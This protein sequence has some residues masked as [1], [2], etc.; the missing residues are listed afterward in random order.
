MDLSIYLSSLLNNH[1]EVGVNGLGTF[2][3]KKV[4]GRYDAARHMFLP[5][6]SALVFAAE[7]REDTLLTDLVARERQLTHD[8]ASAAVQDFASQ[9]REGIR[10][11]GSYQLNGLGTLRQA[12]EELVFEADANATGTEFYGLPPM[13]EKT[14]SDPID[15]PVSGQAAAPDET[16]PANDEPADIPSI[17]VLP[18]EQVDGQVDG[19]NSTETGTNV[20]EAQP[21]AVETDHSEIPGNS[22]KAGQPADEQHGAEAA[23]LLPSAEPEPPV[24]APAP[25]KAWTFDKIEATEPLETRTEQE[26]D[27][28]EGNGS[29]GV[30]R[31]LLVLVVLVAV[32][33]LAYFLKP[34]W[35]GKTP[36][37][38]VA[39]VTLPEAPA[40][41]DTPKTDTAAIRK[42]SS[43]AMAAV[44]PV[45]ATKR[46]DTA[47]RSA[48]AA[49][50]T[51]EVIA[52]AWQTEKKAAAYVKQM[53]QRGLKARRVD[54]GGPMIKISIG[55]FATYAEA[56]Q[57]LPALRKK[58]GS[59]GAY[60]HT[61]K[62]K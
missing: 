24:V 49:P 36:A 17:P 6:A 50:V 34:E 39:P 57:N 51:Y 47:I 38:P 54:I 25:A 16:Q 62:P 8:D 30:L 31:F 4:P 41:T 12:G 28:N 11:A 37:E 44:P 13:P 53:K 9:V 60:I 23:G 3:K 19:Q 15:A 7:L 55:S 29:S 20:S 52:S 43:A 45:T 18:E 58:S 21:A 61:K 1:K 26:I 14:F 2:S 27:S 10:N 59:A 42:D 40:V 33:A 35:F 22:L 48:A 5:P 32:A 46:P 56:E